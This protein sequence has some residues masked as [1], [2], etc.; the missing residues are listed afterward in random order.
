MDRRVIIL[1]LIALVLARCAP[2]GGLAGQD[3]TFEA[4]VTDAAGVQQRL[5][6]RICRPDGPGPA[7]L[8][9]INHG[10]PPNSDARPRM[11]LNRCGDEVARWFTSRGYA[12]V[13]A[14]RRGYGATGG[15]WAEG[16]GRCDQADYVRSGLESAR[17]IAAVVEAAT[18][19]PGIR[20]DG[21]V[22]VGQSAGGWGT[23][24]L[25]SQPHPKVAAFV[26]MAGGR[27]GH[28]DMTPNR[29]CHPER[30]A[31]AAGQYGASARTPMLWMY[32]ANDTY[33]APSVAEAMHS[34]F[35]AAGGS[36]D[37]V[38]P[39]PFGTDG[40]RLFFGAGGSAVWGPVVE[41]YLAARGI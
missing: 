3:N 11:V 7:R 24:A 1:A 20:R 39:G 36:A 18:M 34:A 30:L 13:F 29:N 35:T 33:F 16:Y 9:V 26:V 4:P 19:L 40:H 12:A 5:Q 8:V 41:R 17:D 32:A 23:I 14:L 25:D 10:S 27:G 22:V 15:A 2:P 21:A 37:L 6:A 38:Q 31:E 28:Q